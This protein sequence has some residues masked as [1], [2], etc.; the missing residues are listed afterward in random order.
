MRTKQALSFLFA[1]LLFALAAP[2]CSSSV[3]ETGGSGGNG[4][5]SGVGGS[6]N[7]GD[8]PQAATMLDVEKAQGAGASYPKPTLNARCEGDLFVVDTNA[9]PHY[10]F[11]ATTPNPLVEQNYQYKITRNPQ[12]AQ[13]T[14]KLP[15]LGTAGFAVNG[16]PFFGPNEGAQPPDEAYGDPIYNGL[17]DACEGHTAYTYHYHSMSVKCLSTNSLVAEPWMNPDPPANEASP[18]VGW[19]LDGFPIYGPQECTDEACSQV[20]VLKS[21]YAQT[22]DPHSNAWDAY[23]WQDHP[24]DPSFLDECNGHTGPGGDYHYHATSSFP[25]IVG[26]Y[27]GTPDLNQGGTMPNSGGGTGG[28]MQGG[29]TSCTTNADCNGAC[30]PGSL[31]CACGDSPMGK[32]CV[33][34]C[35]TSPDCP[36]GPMGQQLQCQNGLCVP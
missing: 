19:A 13:A 17:M 33:P 36:Q 9:I 11:V 34:T 18:I 1:S 5:T 16:M 22:G 7:P 28:G 29:P 23:T 15:L 10:T 32:I 3:S 35:M 12:V 30:P 4:G 6:Q 24:G 26:C 25:Y 14:T 2:A 8:C 27:R 21:G 31:G 20:V